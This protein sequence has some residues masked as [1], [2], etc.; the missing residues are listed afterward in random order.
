MDEV[1]QRR[2]TVL[3][4]PGTSCGLPRGGERPVLAIVAS[5][6]LSTLAA[7]SGP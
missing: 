2:V 5:I 7:V 1:A 3:R 4:M 6:A